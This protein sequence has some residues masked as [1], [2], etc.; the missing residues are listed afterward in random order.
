MEE[1]RVGTK[2]RRMCLSCG[3]P[4]TH[5]FGRLNGGEEARWLCFMHDLNPRSPQELARIR[6]KRKGWSS[7]RG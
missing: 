1:P 4:T 5:K 7:S 6:A 3:E 2:A